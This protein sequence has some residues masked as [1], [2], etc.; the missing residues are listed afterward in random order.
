MKRQKEYRDIMGNISVAD[1]LD[2]EA[3]IIDMKTKINYI[4][5]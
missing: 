2:L 3:K 5:K 1:P 4:N